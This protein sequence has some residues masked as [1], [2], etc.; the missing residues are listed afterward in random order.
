MRIS[1]FFAILALVSLPAVAFAGK[2][3]EADP[4]PEIVMT[5]IGEFDGVF[6]K[7]KGI[8]D[9]LTSE[10]AS[11]KTARENVNTALEVA[12]DS[13]L[14]TALADLM[15]KADKKIGVAM[16]GRMPKLSASDAVPDNVQKGIDAVNGL[17]KAADSGITTAAGLKTDAVA[18]AEEAKGF[19]G[20]LPSLVKNPMEVMSKG[21]V[22]GDD[23]K[24]TAALADRVQLLIDEAGKILTDIQSAFGA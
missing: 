21:K 19:P 1:Q 12:T 17:V 4:L 9:K 6:G 8:Q 11:L 24:A 10:T 3:K 5:G 18:L 16:D 22:L 13:P 7:A 14:E 23:V 2:A 20:K 15:K